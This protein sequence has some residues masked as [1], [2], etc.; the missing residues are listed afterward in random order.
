MTCGKI[1]G[2]AVGLPQPLSSDH[3]CQLFDSD[4]SRAT[5]VA[6]FLAA[7]IEGGEY[8]LAVPRVAHWGVIAAELRRRGISVDEEIARGRLAVS[9]A[10]STLARICPRGRL[11]HFAF[12]ELVG[13]AVRPSNGRA[14]RAWGEMVDI[15]I[16]RDDL[17][18][19]LELEELW[20]G[21]TEMVPI[22]LMCSY[23]A[24]RF[25]PVSTHRG[26]RDLCLAHT[27]VRRT[28][29]DPLAD[30]VLTMAHHSAGPSSL[31]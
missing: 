21:V 31:H 4:E 15:L 14:M 22:A 8:V 19:A 23:T 30:W 24:A 2:Y 20:N 17:A 16:E 6:E 29:Q 3:V 12:N 10:A 25:V 7:G 1:A 13:A 26:L 5:A 18:G 27:G 11:N 9:D 28:P